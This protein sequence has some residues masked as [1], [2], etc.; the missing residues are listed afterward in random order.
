MNWIQNGAAII[1]LTTLAINIP[2]FVYGTWFYK[3]SDSL[4][5]NNQILYSRIQVGENMYH[6]LNDDINFLVQGFAVGPDNLL[7]VDM[8]VDKSKEY[9]KVKS[10]NNN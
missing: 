9:P 5:V 6:F 8:R 1:T 2:I 4:D 3:K 10:Y 7:R